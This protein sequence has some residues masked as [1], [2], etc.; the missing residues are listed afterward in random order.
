M[1]KLSILV[2]SLAALSLTT[3]SGQDTAPPLVRPELKPEQVANVLKQLDDLEKTILTQR[4]GDLGGI[5]QRLRAAASSE[6]AAINLLADC[7]K[8]V[9]VDRKADDKDSKEQAERRAEQQKKRQEAATKED[10]ERNGDAGVALRLALEYLA[11]TLEANEAKDLATMVPKIQTF[12]KSLLASADKLKGRA[13]DSLNQPVGTG[14]DAGG[15]GQGRRG[16]A[17]TGDVGL[18]VE[19]FQLAPFLRRQGWPMVPAAIMDHYD[20]LMLKPAREKKPDDLA[21][22]WD[23]AMAT[24]AAYRK[25]RMFEGEYALWAQNEA[26]ALKWAK[27][28]DITRYSS[29][30]VNGLAE[31]LNVIR[32]YPKHASAPQWVQQLRSLVSPAEA[33]ASAPSPPAGQ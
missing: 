26:P 3:L 22:L 25:A 27:A 13:G 8:L 32:A 33:G 4:G 21:S 12:H 14:A 5:I 28:Q 2:L 24:E 11:L 1:K 20:K 19:A 10:Q 6:A 17:P 29:A 7:D 23:G 9:N 16:G 31:M 15:G 18:V 30:P